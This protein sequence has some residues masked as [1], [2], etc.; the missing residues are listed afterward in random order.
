MK[1]NYLACLLLMAVI[2]L[3]SCSGKRKIFGHTKRW[4]PANFEPA[5]T[6]LL[7][8][9]LY[10]AKGQRLMRAYMA[11][12]Y[13]FRYEVTSNDS[14]TGKLG[15]YADTKLY[16]YALVIST[17]EAQAAMPNPS[18]A[19]VTGFDF[20]FYDRDLGRH[21]PRTRKGSSFPIMTFRP[22]INTIVKKFPKNS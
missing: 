6:V 20:N 11:D 4:I 22:V 2:I 3:S 7:V 16:R 15:R 18:S 12:K 10:T 13:P 8:E 14:I 9:E 1:S 21:Y 19:S 17:H 5:N